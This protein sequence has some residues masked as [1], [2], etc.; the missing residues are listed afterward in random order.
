MIVGR[1]VAVIGAG[2]AGL[3]LAYE[4]AKRGVAVL[5]LEATSQ[6]SN[7][8]S[9]TCRAASTVPAA[10]VNPYR[11]RTARARDGD[12]AGME[13]FWRLTGELEALGLA[14]GARSSGV[15]RVA[16]SPR[17]ARRWREIVASHPDTA[18][19]GAGEV[20]S[21]VHAP[22]GALL[23]RR[24]GSVETG[25]FLTAV[26]AAATGLGAEIRTGTHVVASRVEDGGIVLETRPRTPHEPSGGRVD[27]QP[28]SARHVVICVGASDGPPGCRLPRLSRE[29][30]V[31]AVLAPDAAE[32]TG[33]AIMPALAGAVNATFL[34]DRVVVTGGS[35]P[36][37]QPEPDDLMTAASGLRDAIGWAV[38]GLRE[39]RLEAAWFG[40]RARRPSGT[41][42]V[43][44]LAPRVT[45]YGGLAGRGFLCSAHLSANLAERLAALLTASPR[46]PR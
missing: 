44:R 23:V 4:L 25:K 6:G 9:G 27:L 7:V 39:A 1:D 24:G 8:A 21:P 37:E 31:A 29:G 14:H 16:S 12:L 46:A 42:V 20:P 22:H 5:V 13:G 34:P 35:L 33:L 10:L 41:P 3:T 11:G 26:T 43:R 15:I 38:P 2:V 19:L 36:P 17:Q 18:W 45:Y 32:T 30:G 28:M 40:V